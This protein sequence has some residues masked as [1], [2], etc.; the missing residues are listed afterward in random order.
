MACTPV[1]SGLRPGRLEY[2][3]E[4]TFGTSPTDPA[5]SRFSD[6]YQSLD[7]G[8]GA[9][10]TPRRRVGDAD[11]Q[12]FNAG[13]EESSFDV[14][15][16]LQQWISS[17]AAVDGIVRQSNGCLESHTI[18]ERILLGDGAD[19]G[20]RRLYTVALGSKINT[21]SA[22]G[23]PETGN[24]IMIT[25]NYIV[26]KLRAYILDQPT[27]TVQLE[28][29]SSDVADT[30]QDVT[31]EQDDL[32]SETVTLNGTTAVTTVKT[33]WDSLDAVKLSAETEG[34]VTVQIAGGGTVLATI[35]GK[36]S[37]GDREG[38]LG[39]PLTGSGSHAS[40]I[41]GSFE[42]L[43]GDTVERPT[44]TALLDGVDII[45]L[46]FS[47]DNALE[48]QASHQTIGKKIFE[49][50]RT[51]TVPASIFGEKAG[52]ESM[53]EHFRNVENEIVWTLTGGTLTFNN[54]VLTDLGSISRES[55]QAIMTVDTTFT[56]RS[57]TIAP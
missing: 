19:G 40:A 7:F 56:A 15:Y 14:T 26:Q 22:E 13:A 33:D 12:A 24:P 52:F 17:D 43:I 1:E 46:G 9:T 20:G 11:I 30:S 36:T 45:T 3:R 34:D 21:V 32:T 29:L 55:E 50:P 42:N 28:V 49:G 48:A 25:L 51:I 6:A 35:H 16:D 37:Y 8:P 5:W 27:G 41:G 38:D 23:E 47:V 4:V 39:V 54:A 44:G 53:S 18:V 57:L 10:I 31:I 2:V